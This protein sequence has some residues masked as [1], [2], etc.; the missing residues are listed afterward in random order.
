MV[1]CD[2]LSGWYEHSKKLQWRQG[3]TVS[4]SSSTVPDF[5]SIVKKLKDD[6]TNSCPVIDESYKE[7]LRV[8]KQAD[9]VDCS[10][11][12]LMALDKTTPNED[13]SIQSFDDSMW[14]LPSS[15][16]KWLTASERFNPETSPWLIQSPSKDKSSITQT[17]EHFNPKTSPW[18]I[19]SSSKD[20]SSITQPLDWLD[21]LKDETW[22]SVRT[23]E[24]KGDDVSNQGYNWSSDNEQWLLPKGHY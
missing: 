16:D 18:L 21:T 3:A 17:S 6:F 4:T 12:W 10:S 5:S 20:K 8:D 22:L 2:P 23:Y 15:S 7:W 14:L 9:I 19:Q 1:K 24:R 13:N 11:K